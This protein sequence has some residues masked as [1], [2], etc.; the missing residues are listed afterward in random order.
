MHGL[1][2]RKNIEYTYVR[3]D[4][5]SRLDRIYV[6]EVANYIT[7]INVN[8]L[9]FPDYSSVIINLETPNLAKIGRYYWK[10]NIE[11]VERNDIKEIFKNEWQILNV[12]ITYMFKLTH[13]ETCMQRN[14]LNLISK[15][16]N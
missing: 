6:Y 4:Y 15:Q 11:L 7:D 8:N 10:L 3:N 2:K 5:G 16:E 12:L 1:L 9:S 14:K 13:G